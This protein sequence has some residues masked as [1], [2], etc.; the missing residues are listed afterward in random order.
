[1]AAIGHRRLIGAHLGSPNACVGEFHA[2][3]STLPNL[4]NGQIGPIGTSRIEDLSEVVP[5][6]P[7][8][9]TAE[10]THSVARLR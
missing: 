9:I 5:H 8:T 7:G 1:M 10:N 3:E 6:S 4:Y 2:T